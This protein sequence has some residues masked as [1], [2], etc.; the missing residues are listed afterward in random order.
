[1]VS[2]DSGAGMSPR[3]RIYLSLVF[4]CICLSKSLLISILKLYIKLLRSVHFLVLTFFVE[5]KTRD[6]I[7]NS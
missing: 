1:L 3:R 2:L 6:G 7:I 5:K 4:A